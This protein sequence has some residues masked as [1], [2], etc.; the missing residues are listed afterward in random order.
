ML[1]PFAQLPAAGTRTPFATAREDELLLDFAPE[2]L[3]RLNRIE[4]AVM[5]I[6][7]S[8]RQT[9]VAHP[10]YSPRQQSL[11]VAHLAALDLVENRA[12]FVEAATPASSEVDAIFYARTAELLRAY[13]EQVTPLSRLASFQGTVVGVTA[14]RRVVAPLALDY[15]VW[16]RPAHAFANSLKRSSLSDGS[17]I[18]LREIWVTG[19]FSARARTKIESRGIEVTE[20][21]LGR[22]A[23]RDASGGGR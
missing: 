2:D 15:A 9:F 14:D 22:P 19:S 21:A 20:R 3:R 5:G 23:A 11:L 17:E 10:W 6:P 1:V 13:H 16:T 7:E 8:L 4:L 12:A 18:A